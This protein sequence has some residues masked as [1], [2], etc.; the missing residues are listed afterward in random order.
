MFSGYNTV[1]GSANAIFGEGAGYGVAANSFSSSTI[2][3]YQAGYSLANGSADNILLG[4]QAGYNVTTGTGNIIVGYNIGPSGATAN[5]EINIGNVYKGN[6]SSGTA[7]IPKF[8]VQAADS[9]ITL[10]SAD[11]GKTITVN[12]ASAQTVYLPSVT[13][14][15]IG[16]TVTVVKLNAGIVTIQAPSGVYISDSGSAGTIYNNT[17]GESYATITLRLVNDTKWIIIGGD[18]SWTTTI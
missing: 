3:G 13:A 1:T 7:T 6:I 15:D 11:F 12:S 16:A 10:T 5:N 4:W 18:G 8:T 17:S 9:G 2:V 14:A